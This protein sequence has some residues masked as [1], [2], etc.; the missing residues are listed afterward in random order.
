MAPLAD[1]LPSRSQMAANILKI[2]NEANEGQMQDGVSWYTT[3]HHVAARLDPEDIL[4]AAGVI[5][6]LSPRMEWNRNMFLAERTYAEG[7]AYGCLTANSAK[8]NAI[9]NGADVVSTLKAPKTVAFALTIANPEDD[10]LVVVDRHAVS[11]ALGRES[12]DA[13]MAV[14]NRKGGYDWYADAYREAAATLGVLPSTAQAATWTV[15]RENYIRV[16][17][18]VRR[19]AGR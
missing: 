14:L 5:S 10:R 8:A 19:R 7:K 11:V 18:S 16:A 12:T 13:D 2:W 9:Y 3:V 1:I 15:W 4:R 17:A 6:A